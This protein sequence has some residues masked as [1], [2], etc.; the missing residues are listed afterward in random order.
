MFLVTT[1]QLVLPGALAAQGGA[2]WVHA[3]AQVVA[4]YTH[5]DPVPGGG[6]LAEARA[7][8]PVALLNAGAGHFSVLATL[9]FE[10]L[11]IPNGE[12]T[13]GA[14]G[15]GFMDRR[16]PHTYAHELV[17]MV[18]DV[19]GRPDGAVALSAALG[20]GFVP[21]GTDDPM[22][23]PVER[24]PVNHHLA[25]ILERAFVE[26]GVRGGPARLEG[27]LFNGDEPTQP[28]DW[29]ILSH[30]GD[31]WA[32]RLT[33][34]PV[35]GVEVQASL[36]HVHSPEHR[37]GAG[38]D[39]NKWCTSIRLDRPWADRQVYGLAELART[40]EADGFFVYHSALVEGALT[41]RRST[42]YARIERTDRPE[43]ERTLDPFRSVRPHVEN[44]T[45]GTTRWTILTTGYAH[46][47]AS[48][49]QHAVR[50]AP[51]VELSYSTVAKADSGALRPASVLRRDFLLDRFRGLRGS[52]ANGRASHGPVPGRP[53]GK[54]CDGGDA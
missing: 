5:Q 29:P 54:S 27:A 26:V 28:T 25:Q 15:E 9:N 22:S 20:K 37:G 45:L 13:I 19:L 18:H 17:L 1:L 44:A 11:T 40:S 31:S 51:F 23:R 8:Q 12:L 32:T 34:L 4:V 43:E 30:L 39:Q 42:L 46:N 16:H 49:A 38:P 14:W 52:V 33:L 41:A 3:G 47:F 7:V 24:Y 2:P 21:F 36:A 50:L 6:S 53:N 10:G 48:P 35:Q